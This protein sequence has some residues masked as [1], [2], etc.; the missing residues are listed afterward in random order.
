MTSIGKAALCGGLALSLLPATS[1]AGARA[2]RL[3]VNSGR[4][5]QVRPAMIV[6]GMVAITGA[7][8]SARAFQAGHYGHI[9]WTRWSHEAVGRG[10]AWVPNGPGG[11]VKPYPASVRASRVEAGRYTRIWWAYGSGRHRYQE[12]DKLMRFGGSYGWRVVRYTGG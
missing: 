1:A 6:Q 7:H 2:P 10:R 5:F 9:R 3:L 12:W 11:A 4:S 8:V